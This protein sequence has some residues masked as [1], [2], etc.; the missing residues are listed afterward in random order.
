MSVRDIFWK[1][2]LKLH[3]MMIQLMLGRFWYL[4]I[5]PGIWQSK[6]FDTLRS[7]LGTRFC[8]YLLKNLRNFKIIAKQFAAFNGRYIFKIA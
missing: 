2:K 3:F 8:K 5:A 1:Q 4:D 7:K 6:L